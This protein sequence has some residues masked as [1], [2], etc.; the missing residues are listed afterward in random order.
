MKI[1]IY[2]GGRGLIEDPTLNV[3]SNI[4]NVLDDLRVDVERY[5]LYNNRQGIYS[6]PKTINEANAVI[7]AASSEWFGIGGYMQQFLDAC[8]LYGD[9]ELFSKVYALPIVVSNSIYEEEQIYFLKKS[10]KILGFKVDSD[11]VSYVSDINVFERNKD[12]TYIIEKKIEKFYKLI[13][14][15]SFVLPTSNN[16]SI[17]Y[18]IDLTPYETEQLSILAADEEF[19][20]TKKSDIDELTKMFQTNL[21]KKNRNIID[22]LKSI[23]V[24]KGNVDITFAINITDINKTIIFSENNFKEGKY[25]NEELF[26]KVKSEFIDNILEKNTNFYTLFLK[27]DIIVKGNINKLRLLDNLFDL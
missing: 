3:I 25:I 24:G 20:K 5:D 1:N 13:S 14:K 2:Y 11:I 9:K 16:L 18:N 12:Y 21:N 15:N 17:N 22:R 19:I 27:G 8:Y 4:I 23:Y 7:F 6:L 10:L 26:I